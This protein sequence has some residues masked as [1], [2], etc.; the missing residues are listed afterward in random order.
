MNIYWV[1]DKY[2]DEWWF[3]VSLWG[4]W[5]SETSLR[6]V[7][8]FHMQAT[9]AHYSAY[10]FLT[11]EPWKIGLNFCSSVSSSAKLCQYNN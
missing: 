6:E 4:N 9:V 10:H 2:L 3:S 7:L 8:D 11:V 5:G 1:D